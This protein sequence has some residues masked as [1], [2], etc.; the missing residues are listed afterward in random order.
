MA[1]QAA[2]CIL[3]EPMGLPLSEKWWHVQTER[4]RYVPSTPSR[5]G[6]KPSPY[7]WGPV[8]TNG[9]LS[10]RMEH[11]WAQVGETVSANIANLNRFPAFRAYRD[12]SDR[13]FQ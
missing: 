12:H 10:L 1:S 4:V 6:G 5:T 8:P 13:F 2:S 7:E 9:A 3:L 11:V